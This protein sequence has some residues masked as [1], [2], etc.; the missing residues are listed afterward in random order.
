MQQNV[1]LRRQEEV[2]D[3]PID[4]PNTQEERLRELEAKMASIAQMLYMFKR[5]G[6]PKKVARTKKNTTQDG[7]PFNSCFLGYTKGS[8]YPFILVITEEGK[9]MIGDKEFDT[10]D[11]ATGSI[12]GEDVDS[13]LFWQTFEGVSL[14]EFIE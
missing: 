2:P 3:I 5:S 13:Y 1:S 7:V 8:L 12:C 4:S 9:Y 11:S 14:A 6:L 10:L